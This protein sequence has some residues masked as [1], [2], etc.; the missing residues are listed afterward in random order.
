VERWYRREARARIRSSLEREGA[1]LG[2]HGRSLAIR[3][4]RS[5]W[6]SCSS[7]GRLSFSWRLLVAPAEVLRYVVVHELCHLPEPNHGARF[8]QLVEASLPGWRDQRAWLRRHGGELLAYAPR[9]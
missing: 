8:W 1:R 3:D 5:R 4:P 6:A 7:S 2:L 9:V